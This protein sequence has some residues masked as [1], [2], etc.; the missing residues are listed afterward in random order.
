MTNHL[1]GALIGLA[2]GDAL[3]AAVEFKS[4]GSF[5]PV[6]GYRSG[7]P[8]GLNVGEWT[9][10][11]SMALALAD[12]IATAGWNLNDQASRYV[13]WWKTG[14]YSVNGRCFDIGITTRS[15]LSRFVV[16]KNAL[17]S[18]DTSDRA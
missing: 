5:A 7:G 1:R 6:T 15:A 18:G 14:K 9:D 11:T 16:S 4:P 3:G 17:T 8:H 10:D 2:V 12:S 13:E